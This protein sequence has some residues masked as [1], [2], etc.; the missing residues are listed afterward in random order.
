MWHIF[1][2]SSYGLK[3][4]QLILKCTLVFFFLFLFMFH[5]LQFVKTVLIIIVIT[6]LLKKSMICRKKNILQFLIIVRVVAGLKAGFTQC[7]SGSAFLPVSPPHSVTVCSLFD[8]CIH[9]I[10]FSWCLNMRC[11]TVPEFR[12]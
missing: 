12:L 8:S 3:F 6:R 10:C 7:H 5:S 2:Y 4:K 9:V 11:L 1:T